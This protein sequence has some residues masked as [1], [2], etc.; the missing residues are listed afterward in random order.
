MVARSVSRG[1]SSTNEPSLSVGRTPSSLMRVSCAHDGEAERV[2][3][4]IAQHQLACVA[5]RVCRP[6]RRH[7]ELEL[8]AL[9]QEEL[10]DDGVGEQLQLDWGV[11]R[12]RLA[13]E[14]VAERTHD[15]A[16][17]RQERNHPAAAGATLSRRREGDGEPRLLARGDGRYCRRHR[18]GAGWRRLVAASLAALLAARLAHLHPRRHVQT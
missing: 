7:L 12:R 6:N 11:V 15:G 16:R 8:G 10:R 18:E 3:L 4:A 9:G 5:R 1:G 14:K 13:A 17:V 2:R